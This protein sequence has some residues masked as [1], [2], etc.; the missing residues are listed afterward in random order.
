MLDQR[1]EA[2]PDSAWDEQVTWDRL[3]GTSMPDQHR[4]AH[5]LLTS[6]A[7]VPG[8]PIV[9]ALDCHGCLAAMSC[10]AQPLGMHACAV[11]SRATFHNATF[12]EGA[13]QADSLSYS[14]WRSGH[15]AASSA[16]SVSSL[17]GS[18]TWC[19]K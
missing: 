14:A 12:E 17:A 19:L 8:W 15:Q 5:S 6:L 11:P 18:G 3:A 2:V 4:V 9:L 13:A 7:W 10:S 16:R 1:H